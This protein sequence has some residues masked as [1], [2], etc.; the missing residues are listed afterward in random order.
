MVFIIG[1]VTFSEISALRF[2][3]KHSEVRAM[4]CKLQV[5]PHLFVLKCKIIHRF[6]L[7]LE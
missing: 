1:G 4:A 2:L 6:S 3:S 7:G 5:C